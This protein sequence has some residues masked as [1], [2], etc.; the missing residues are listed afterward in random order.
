MV[1]NCRPGP[2]L[3]NCCDYSAEAGREDEQ[4]AVEISVKLDGGTRVISGSLK[5]QSSKVVYDFRHFSIPGIASVKPALERR[6]NCLADWK[7]FCR[8]LIV[9][10]ER[11]LSGR[12]RHHQLLKRSK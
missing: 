5:T 2:D 7:N 12:R 8:P 11:F 10:V 3:E 1:L 9:E 6:R 4:K